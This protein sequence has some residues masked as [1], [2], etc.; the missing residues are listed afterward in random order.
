MNTTFPVVIGNL[1]VGR[2]FTVAKI[3]FVG[4]TSNNDKRITF[5]RYC[6]K[7]FSIPK[8]DEEPEAFVKALREIVH[9][10]GTGNPLFVTNDAHLKVMLRY[11]EEFHQMFSGIFLKK[12]M[13]EISLDK[14][15]FLSLARSYKMP[16][17]PTYYS[18]EIDQLQE[19]DFPIIVKPLSRVSWFQS[20]VVQEVGGGKFYKVLKFATKSE[21]DS[22][23]SRLNE[24]GV[25]YLVQ[26]DIPGPESNI[27]SFHSFFTE[28]S[29]PLCAFVG[30]K[31]RTYPADY[32]MSTSLKLIKHPQIV[33][34][35]IDILKRIQYVGPVKI[36][37]KLDEDTGKIYLLEINTR[38]NIWHYL[39]ARAGINIPELAYNYLH[40][41]V[42]EK[43]LTEYRTDIRWLNF[44]ND[45]HSFW[46]LR[47]K[48]EITLGEWLKSIKGRRIYQTLAFDDP[49]PVL[50]G[51]LKTTQGIFRRMRRLV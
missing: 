35:S 36:D 17:P 25:Q 30:R 37:Y 26:K 29:E 48:G 3:P 50:Y 10:I 19:A 23:R 32:G 13:I 20:K 41:R 33:E 5:S 34:E 39:G 1:M 22:I 46:E 16:I 24:E 40:G 44:E 12:E 27:L 6:R 43:P 15:K 38:Y 47:R 7:G 28:K 18:D 9:E 31:I 4:I 11:W 2:C 8:P 42:P 49:L 21:F 14:S 51:I 45:L